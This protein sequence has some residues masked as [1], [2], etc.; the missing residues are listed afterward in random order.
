M[1][2]LFVGTP[3]LRLG[4][5]T[6]GPHAEPEGSHMGRIIGL[7]E[8]QVALEGPPVHRFQRKGFGYF[9]LEYHIGVCIL[10]VYTMASTS[11]YPPPKFILYK[12]ALAPFAALE[13]VASTV[14]FAP[15]LNL[16]FCFPYAQTIYVDG[17]HADGN[18]EV[19]MYVVFMTVCDSWVVVY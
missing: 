7:P 17:W 9:Y 2:N 4:L 6:P 16:V 11:V 15:F 1:T 3:E 12:C 14:R 5:R 19:S 18:L 10:F 8:Y 13:P